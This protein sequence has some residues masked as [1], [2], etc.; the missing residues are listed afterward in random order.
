MRGGG[1]Q[2]V[3]RAMAVKTE[4]AS[5]VHHSSPALWPGTYRPWTGPDPWPRGWGL[6]LYLLFII[7]LCI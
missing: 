6:L 2:A 1:A 4:E 7:Y 3:M 5:L